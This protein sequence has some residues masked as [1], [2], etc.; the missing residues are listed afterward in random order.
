[1]IC[2]GQ[3]PGNISY[4][5]YRSLESRIQWQNC[6]ARLLINAFIV[7][8]SYADGG[9]IACS[10]PARGGSRPCVAMIAA[11]AALMGSDFYL[12][13]LSAHGMSRDGS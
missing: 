12:L 7:L 6:I 13:P 8:R 3:Q 1:M 10:G 4:V 5:A 9:R 11:Q 2:P